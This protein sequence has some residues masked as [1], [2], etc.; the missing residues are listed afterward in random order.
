MPQGVYLRPELDEGALSLLRQGIV[1]HDRHLQLQAIRNAKA[2][3]ANLYPEAAKITPVVSDIHDNR[4]KKD[5][6]DLV[7]N[8]T[9]IENRASYTVLYE[10][11]AYEL[12]VLSEL[13]VYQTSSILSDGVGL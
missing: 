5:I 8:G 9:V 3:E 6:S 1:N 12:H 4:I 2:Q 7:L 11:R 13:I 10:S